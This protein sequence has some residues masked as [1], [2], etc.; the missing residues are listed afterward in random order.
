[1]HERGKRTK[2]TAPNAA[3]IFE[4]QTNADY[5]AKENIDKP[6]IARVIDELAAS[7]FSI[8]NELE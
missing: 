3:G 6:F 7:I 8:N 4:I 2:E 1:M 5:A